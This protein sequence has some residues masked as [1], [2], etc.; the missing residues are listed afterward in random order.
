MGLVRR[1]LVVWT[2]VTVVNVAI[3]S[4]V[5]GP[6]VVVVHEGRKKRLAWG[7][8]AARGGEG[9]GDVGGKLLLL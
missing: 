8:G 4:S 3:S 6:R 7:G 1:C 5:G 2:V 9:D